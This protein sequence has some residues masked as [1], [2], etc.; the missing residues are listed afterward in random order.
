VFKLLRKN[1][2]ISKI[3]D[4]ITTLLDKNLST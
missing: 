1:G 3:R 2:Y 4:T